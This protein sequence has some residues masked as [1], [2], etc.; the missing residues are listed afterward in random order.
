MTIAAP[1]VSDANPARIS[2]VPLPDP[3]GNTLT[4][5]IVWPYRDLNAT[6]RLQVRATVGVQTGK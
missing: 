3:V 2:G 1:L 6:R 5:S 4:P